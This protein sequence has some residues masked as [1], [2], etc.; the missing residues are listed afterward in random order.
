MIR[1][2]TRRGEI[3]V[4]RGRAPRTPYVPELNSIPEASLWEERPPARRVLPL[5]H[6]LKPAN[7]RIPAYMD[8]PPTEFYINNNSLPNLH[9]INSSDNK[10]VN[11]NY[12]YVSPPGTPYSGG[13]R[14]R[15]AKKS[16]TKRR[17]RR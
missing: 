8:E 10:Y 14:K 12:L 5:N 17:A 3:P 6:L 13:T 4:I 16:K 9:I 7:T 15:R 2:K 11:S 1:G